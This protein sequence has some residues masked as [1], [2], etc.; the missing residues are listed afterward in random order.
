MTAIDPKPTPASQPSL[1]RI[2]AL[3][4]RPSESLAC[5]IKTWLDLALAEHQIIVVRTL[6]ALRNQN[7]GELVLGFNDKTLLPDQAPAD[8]STRYH[9]DTLQGLESRYASDCFE[10]AMHW[11]DRDGQSYPVV[12]VPAGVQSPVAAKANLKTADKSIAANDI[13]VRSLNASGIASTTKAKWNDWS[14]LVERCFDNREADI[15]RF[16]R[17]HLAGLAPEASRGALSGLLD[18]CPP[19]L[20]WDTVV[21]EALDDGARRF[22]DAAKERQLE[23]PGIGWWEVALVIT[24]PLASASNPTRE[25]LAR[26]GASN[27]NL[28]GWPI[29]QDTRTML[30]TDAQPEVRDGAWQALVNYVG[31]FRHIDFLRWDPQGRFYLRWGFQEDLARNPVGHSPIFDAILPVL[32]C[33]EAIAVGVAFARALGGTEE[34]QLEFAF[35]WSGL[36]GRRLDNWSNSEQVFADGVAHDDAIT[37]P[38]QLPLDTPSL[39]IGAR[40]GQMLAPLYALFDGFVLPPALAENIARRLFERRV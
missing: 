26:L 19:A 24:G 9:I 29:W 39:A 38:L 34:T 10:I 32:R 1:A 14:G 37:V 31:A 12:S 8:V 25:F 15:G 36:R 35:R 2:K 23:L 30:Q 27:P 17:R 11:I 22:V 4:D 28:T 18:F 3:V 21:R 33:A 40:V 7:G 16:L 13:Y 5:E 6:L 20:S